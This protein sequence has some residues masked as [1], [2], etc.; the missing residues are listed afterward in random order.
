VKHI[1]FSG[2]AAPADLTLVG[3]PDWDNRHKYAYTLI[4]TNSSLSSEDFVKASGTITL[5]LPDATS[6]PEGLPFKIM[7]VGTG[8]ITVAT[9]LSQTIN[10]DTSYI[11][12]NQWQWAELSAD[13]TGN[14]IVTGNN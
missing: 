6:V 5:T 14:W 10:A 9:S 3:G 4:S 12:S 13:E 1:K 8:V 11:L 2:V 7:N